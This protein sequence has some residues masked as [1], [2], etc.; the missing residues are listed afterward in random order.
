MGRE[1]R[2]VPPGWQH[3]KYTQDDAPG[4]DWIGH[5]RPLYDRDY[6]TACEG[7]LAACDHWRA[8]THPAQLKGYGQDYKYYWDYENGPPDRDSYRAEKWAPE[9]ATWYQMYETVSEGTPVTPAFA[10]KEELV[11]YLVAH[12]DYGDQR[13]GEGGWSRANA[14]QFVARGYASSLMVMRA[15]GV[16]TIHAPRDGDLPTS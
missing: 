3:P 6:E 7:W 1:I 10:T 12:G 13:Y 15:P 2:R 4:P 8:G 14:E 5:E 16:V 9:E 11:E